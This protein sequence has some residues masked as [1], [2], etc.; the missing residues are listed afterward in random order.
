MEAFPGRRGRLADSGWA[1]KG[2]RVFGGGDYGGG[3][4]WFYE[5]KAW[6]P[7]N[8]KEIGRV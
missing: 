4:E 6:L 7:Q 2:G 8:V 1:A 3:W 5:M